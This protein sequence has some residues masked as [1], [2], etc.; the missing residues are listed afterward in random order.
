MLVLYELLLKEKELKTMRKN[1]IV[2]SKQNSG[3]IYMIKIRKQESQKRKL[4]RQ[5][6]EEVSEIGHRLKS[7]ELFLDELVCLQRSD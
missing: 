1:S 6:Y 5:P 7:K 3:I 2:I 4:D